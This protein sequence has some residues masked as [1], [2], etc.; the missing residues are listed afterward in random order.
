VQ[1]AAMNTPLIDV[2]L[3]HYAYTFTVTWAAGTRAGKTDT[4]PLAS[5]IF[6]HEFYQPLRNNRALLS[7]AHV[8]KAG[9]VIAW[10]D[11][12][13]IDMAATTIERLAIDQDV[14]KA[15]IA[16]MVAETQRLKLNRPQ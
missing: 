3:H 9:A 2:V 12:D 8:T 15:A 14:R 5:I 10:G 1:Q 13:A 4:V 11:D 6:T 16:Q 7:S